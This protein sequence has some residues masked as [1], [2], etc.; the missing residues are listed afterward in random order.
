M[1]EGNE[2]KWDYVPTKEKETGYEDIINNLNIISIKD[3]CALSEEEQDKKVAEV[4]KMI[5]EKNIFPIYYFNEQGVLKEIKKVFD[6]N[7]VTF[8]DNKLVTQSSQGLLVLDYL[9][10]N[11]HRVEAGNSTNNCMYNRFYD[12]FKLSKC[13]KRFMKNYTFT[14][15]RTPFFMYGRF[16]WNTATN[17]APIRA[18]AIYEKFC[19]KN[20]IIYDYS[21]GFGGRML[22]ALSS[23]NNYTY[24][25]CEPC[26]DT[27]NNLNYLGSQIERVSKRENS[28][29]IFNSCSEDLKLED[30]YYDFIFSCP[31]FYGLERYSTEETQSINK[32]PKY[33]DWL[34]GYVRPTIKN[35]YRALKPNCYFGVDIFDTTWKNKKYSLVNDWRKIIEEEGFTYV[36]SYP[37][38]SRNRKDINDINNIEH[39]HIFKK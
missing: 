22:G 13:L 9:F 33:Q 8:K 32:F 25:G 10:P 20:G 4:I 39:I 21:A 36:D 15:M 17:F 29:K 27:F 28:F 30:N 2:Y 11:L 16:F 31:P 12:D 3:F 19:P 6:K 35:C 34:E 18:K 23:K 24:I 37:I 7:D 14:N 38:I 5:R 1:F 26:K